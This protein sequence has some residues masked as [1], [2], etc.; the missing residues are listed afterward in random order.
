[1]A[2]A[3]LVQAEPLPLS[4]EEQA[5]VDQAIDK[6]IAFLKRMQT[7]KGNWDAPLSGRAVGATA[8]PA[9]ALLEAGVPADDPVVRRAAGC[10]RRTCPS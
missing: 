7:K 3:A 2:T 6:A 8:L 10:L 9:L 1:M 4:K 5:K